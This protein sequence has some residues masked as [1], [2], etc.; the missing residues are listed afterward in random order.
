MSEF[1]YSRDELDMN[2]VLKVNQDVSASLE[3]DTEKTKTRSTADCNISDSLELLQSLKYDK[4]VKDLKEATIKNGSTSATS[5]SDMKLDD[6][7]EIVKQANEYHPQ[8]V[9]IEDIMSKDEIDQSF[10]ELKSINKEFSRKTSIINKTD[11][12]FLSIAIALQ[13]TK[14]LLFPIIAEKFDY[15]KSFD[16]NDRLAHN[17]KSIES[18]HKKANDSFRDKHLTD[19]NKGKW[20]NIVYQTPPYDIT[21]GSKSLGINMG[22]AYHRM[23]TLG[24]DP[25]LG[26]VFGTM[27]ILTD[28]ITFN[29]FSSYRVVRNPMRITSNFVSLTGM[30]GESYDVVRSDRLN[31]P[32]AIFAEAQ[33]LKSDEYTKVGLPVP[34]LETVNEDFASKLYKSNYDALCF[35]RDTKIVTASFIVSKL[36]DVII[37]LTHG[38]FY[39]KVGSRDMFE[40]RTRKILLI[41]N[42]I[43]SSSSIIE[44]AITSNPKNLDIGSLLNTV[45]HLFTDVRFICKIKKEFVEN[46]ISNRMEK[47]LIAIDDLYK[48]F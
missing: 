16:K 37:T 48:T 32:A 40:V 2:K 3:K 24:H 13:V 20:I 43:A 9:S 38:L 23:H 47:E 4:K 8:E 36:I 45:L 28:I 26:W 35:A 22:G 29:N 15:G 1:K 18:A 17:D 7:D 46:E 5:S 44:A 14:S 25:I 6:W 19:D 41:S 11:L 10:Q 21:K 39:D 30:I 42:S 33:H 34:I 31:L 27:N 12:A